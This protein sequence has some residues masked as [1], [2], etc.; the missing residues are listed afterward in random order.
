MTAQMFIYLSLNLQPDI[1]TEE[2]LNWEKFKNNTLI[3][4]V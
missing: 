2:G 4:I 1:L 3:F